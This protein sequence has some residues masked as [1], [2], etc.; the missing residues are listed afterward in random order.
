[1]PDYYIW[2]IIDWHFR[3]QRPQQLA[4]CLANS[5]RRVFYIS[6]D[7]I[8]NGKAGIKIEALD[9][10]HSLFQIKLF[11]NKPSPIYNQA[12]Q[13]DAITQLRE[14]VGK[15]LYWA[16][17]QSVISLVD[18]PFWTQIASALPNNRLIYD[19]MD[20]HQGFTDNNI[21]ATLELE[22]MLL[23]KAALTITTSNYLFKKVESYCKN[24]V[25]IRN[26][27]DYS[28]F[29]RKPENVYQ[30]PQ[31]RKI[32][33]YYGAIAEWFD[34]QLIEK[35]AKEHPE[36][37]VI[38]IG[39]VTVNINTKLV[40][41]PNVIFIGE[42][43]Y[44]RLTFYLY[45]FDICL[46]P[47]KKNSLTLAT[48]PVK[49]YEYLSAGKP[50]VTVDLPEI[51]QFDQLVYKAKDQDDF[52]LKTKLLLENPESP[53]IAQQRQLFAKSQTWDHRFQDLIQQAELVIADPRVT[54][55]LVTYNN[56]SLTKECL[57][58]LERYNQYQ[59]VELII[60]DNASTDGS[61]TFLTHWAS[62]REHCKV[63]LNNTNKGFSA[64][65]NQGLEIATGA[66]L[67]ILN[68]DTYVTPGW[69]RTMV[70]HL[71]N[72]HNIGLIGPVTNNIGNEAK[73]NIT[74][75]NMNE[76][77]QQ[78]AQYTFQHIGKLI[79]LKSAAFFS[80]MM[81]R[82][83]YLRV[84]NLD[85]SFGRGFFEDDDY[86]RRVEQLGLDIVCAEDVFIHHHLSA[87]FNKLPQHERDN[88]FQRNKE[89]YEKKWGQSITH[90]YRNSQTK[91]II[92]LM[93][94]NAIETLKSKKG[95][96]N[97][98]G[99]STRFFYQTLETCRESLICEYCKTTSRY[100]SITRGV[101][102]AI[103]ELT[104]IQS[105]SVSSLPSDGKQ[106][107]TIYDT[108]TPFYFSACAYPL[109]DLLSKI[110]W[111]TIKLSTYLPQKPLGSLI[112]ENVQNQNLESLTYPNDSFD[113][114]IT[115]DVMEHIRLDE[116][117]HQ[118]IYRVL[119]PGGVY[120][121]TVPYVHFWDKTLTRILALNP[122]N[123]D[124]D[125]HLLEPEYHGDTNSEHGKIISYRTY[126]NELIAFLTTL[127]FEVIYD[128]SNFENYGI[129][130][131]E[132]FYCRKPISSC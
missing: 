14:S 31:G 6:P 47:F 80:V 66:Y 98:C 11:L 62:T 27:A 44:S 106:N 13:L 118:E 2:G 38:L 12:P 79:P 65:N 26:A 88:L 39:K 130:N 63:I 7:F 102:T 17:S 128:K 83:T 100:R 10:S 99:L 76:M 89:I 119:K 32:V 70:N 57:E 56:L 53:T 90:Q 115:S 22:K 67:V 69:I 60:V 25:I 114:I 8:Q 77:L 18:H 46:L 34:L 93:Q 120:V 78:S 1:M 104:R 132:L 124:Q 117:A 16:N 5:G 42:I 58:S 82:S 91:K 109:P 125:V 86:C 4:Q 101:L 96:C 35:L 50:V 108:Q 64:A 73:I 112:H 45:S 3:H 110:N 126:G 29:S 49:I 131:T 61:P 51:D 97:V 72:N 23:S 75:T 41:L 33:G 121:F 85:E 92:N 116:Q 107:L 81:P 30:D 37:C 55:V 48:N 113:I 28:Y 105:D 71:E 74:Y 68:N 122:K 21:T 20:D 40:N 111:I 9:K 84:G 87:S 127:G 54:I 95:Q 43:P 15:L 52:L 103:N 59:N 129:I 19:C 24:S 123:P 36:T 94:L